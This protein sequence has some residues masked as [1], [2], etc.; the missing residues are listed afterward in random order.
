ME[1]VEGVC[2]L[3]D[4]TGNII[5]NR[6][7][8]KC[9]YLA[10]EVGGADAGFDDVQQRVDESF[11]ATHLLP[12]LL[13]CRAQVPMATSKPGVITSPYF[14]IRDVMKAHAHMRREQKLLSSVCEK[15]RETP[16]VSMCTI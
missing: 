13:S 1:K 9:T 11:A 3:C 7:V 2:R 12:G 6:Q 16:C 14:H 5:I 8:S 15:G 10:V 4:L